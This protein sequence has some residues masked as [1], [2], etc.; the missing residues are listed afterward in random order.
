MK[1]RCDD[2]IEG[3]RNREIYLESLW[4]SIY[5]SVCFPRKSEKFSSKI[6]RLRKVSFFLDRMEEK[7]PRL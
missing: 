3:D 5:G 1:A 4:Y 7:V 6:R 2:E